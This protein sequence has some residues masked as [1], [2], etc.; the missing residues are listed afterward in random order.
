MEKSASVIA[1]DLGAS[2]GKCFAGVFDGKGFT[3]KEVHRFSHEPATIYTTDRI[4]RVPRSAPSGTTLYIY[5]QI[6]EGLR[7]YRRDIGGDG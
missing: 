6:V 2:G 3:L 7:A 1:V 5:A 4:R